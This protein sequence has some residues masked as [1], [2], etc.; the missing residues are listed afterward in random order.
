MLDTTP[1]QAQE[2]RAAPKEAAGLTELNEGMAKKA[3]ED[4]PLSSASEAPSTPVKEPGATGLEE[5]KSIMKPANNPGDKLGDFIKTKPPNGVELNFSKSGVEG[6]LLEFLELGSQDLGEFILDGVKFVAGSKALKSASNEQLRN[7][8]KILNAYPNAKVVV[9]S[10]TDNLGEKAHNYRLS[11]ERAKHVLHELARIG[12]DKSRLTAKGF[13]DDHPLASNDSEEGRMRNSTYFAICH[14][15]VKHAVA[16][17]ASS[18][19]GEGTIP[20]TTR[21]SSWGAGAEHI[22]CG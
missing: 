15:E 12:V 7:I 20:E 21:D 5:A 2:A 16:S 4:V 17:M 10:Y 14:T 6:K 22:G 1:P 9:N 8:A 13:G 3:R 18:A 11:G 19:G